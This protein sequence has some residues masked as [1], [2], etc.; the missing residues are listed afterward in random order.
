M[1]FP[2]NALRRDRA[3]RGRI[4]LMAAQGLRRASHR[5]REHYGRRPGIVRATRA[6]NSPGGG[7]PGSLRPGNRGANSPARKSPHVRPAEPAA[8]GI[9][10]LPDDSRRPIPYR[11]ISGSNA[12]AEIAARRRNSCWVRASESDTGYPLRSEAEA[13]ARTGPWLLAG[14][15]GRRLGPRQTLLRRQVP[16]ARAPAGGQV[17]QDAS[18][19]PASSGRNWGMATT[20]IADLETPPADRA[21]THEV[22][23]AA[24]MR[25]RL[26]RASP[27]SRQCAAPHPVSAQSGQG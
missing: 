6:E 23:Q 16:D 25:R 9:H 17:G 27:A 20:R 24:T 8:T 14:P 21:A 18:F 26:S 22:A 7:C 4:R 19:H 10:Q 2:G 1:G 13:A 11:A 5:L 12:A 15:C 3:S